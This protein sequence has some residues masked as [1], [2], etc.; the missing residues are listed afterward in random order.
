MLLHDRERRDANNH[1]NRTLR[2]H[3]YSPRVIAAWDALPDALGGL[4]R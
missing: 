3:K 2:L 4:P 1:R